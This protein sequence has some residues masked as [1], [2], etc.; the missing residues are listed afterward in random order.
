MKGLRGAMPTY[1]NSVI[2]PA[3]YLPYT[4]IPTWISRR[5]LPEL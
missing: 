2:D 1:Y 5:R 3:Y 4:Y